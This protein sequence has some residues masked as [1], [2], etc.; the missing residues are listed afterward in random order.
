M[1]LWRKIGVNKDHQ[2]THTNSRIL[3]YPKTG[4]PNTPSCVGIA[5]KDFY[6]QLFSFAKCALRSSKPL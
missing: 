4:N 5:H 6:T 3:M 2:S 1:F